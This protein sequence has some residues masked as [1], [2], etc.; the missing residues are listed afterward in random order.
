MPK[1]VKELASD[2]SDYLRERD[3]QRPM[4]KDTGMK[5]SFPD[6]IL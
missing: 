6:E 2:L 1:K 3:A 4:M 5:I